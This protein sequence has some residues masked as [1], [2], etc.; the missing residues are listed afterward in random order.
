M[1]TSTRIRVF[2]E[3]RKVQF[4]AL[5]LARMETRRMVLLL[6]KLTAS[7]LRLDAV[8]AYFSVL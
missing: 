4:P 5:L 3:A 6:Q 8:R 1:P 2:P 7:E